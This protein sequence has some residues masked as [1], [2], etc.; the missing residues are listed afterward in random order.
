MG[1]VVLDSSVLI[2]LYNRNDLH[3]GIV[4]T[5][6]G[7]ESNQYEISAIGLMETLVAPFADGPGTSDRV[8]AAIDGSIAVIHPVTERIAVAAA[9]IRAKTKMRVPDAIISATATLA[10]AQLWTLDRRLAK[11]H[12]GAVLIA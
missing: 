9:K 4:L 12:K 6:F 2:A 7:S 5:K 11:A 10:E 8:L 3:H 1:R